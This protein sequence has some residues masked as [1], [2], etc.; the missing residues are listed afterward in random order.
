MFELDKK[1]FILKTVQM[2][3]GYKEQLEQ[4]QLKYSEGEAD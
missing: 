4:R 3:S 1:V 2:S